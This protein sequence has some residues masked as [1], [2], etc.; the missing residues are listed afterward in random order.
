MLKKEIPPMETLDSVPFTPREYVMASV[1][2]TGELDFLKGD[3]DSVEKHLSRFLFANHW[4]KIMDEIAACD[5]AG[6]FT[7]F[8]MPDNKTVLVFRNLVKGRK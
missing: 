4:L 8:S 2:A 6:S 1:N 3:Y 7:R 5:A